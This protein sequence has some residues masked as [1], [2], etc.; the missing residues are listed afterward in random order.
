MRPCFDDLDIA[1][2]PQ[3]APRV[4]PDANPVKAK[5]TDINLTVHV[6][7]IHMK[8]HIKPWQ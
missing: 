1:E 2:Q 5:S 8:T 6:T 4:L 3:L 7:N